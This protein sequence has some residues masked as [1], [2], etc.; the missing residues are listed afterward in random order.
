[1]KIEPLGVAPTK[2]KRRVVQREKR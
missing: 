1:V 2:A